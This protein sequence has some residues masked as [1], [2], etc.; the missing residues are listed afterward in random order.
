MDLHVQAS[1]PPTGFV[2]DTMLGRLA[3]WLRMLG[4]DT[5]YDKSIA[6]DL[7]IERA[8]REERW[9]LTSDGYLAQRR[10][11][12]GR[13][14]LIT[15]NHLDGQLGQLRHDLHL[16]LDP[17]GQRP[18]RCATCNVVLRPIAPRE[19][20]PLVPLYVAQHYDHFAQCPCC[21]HVYWPGTHWVAIV[22]RLA[23]IRQGDSS[24]P[25]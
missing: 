14:T 5:A 15:S 25:R 19:A 10:I 18:F 4:Y 8:L 24:L 21:R 17:S 11:L 6:D 7:L 20:I 22:G 3:R 23:A 13:H 2:A 9:L 1:R 12:R 16:S